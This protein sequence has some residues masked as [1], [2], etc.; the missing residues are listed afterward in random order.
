M[1]VK[2]SNELKAQASGKHTFILLDIMHCARQAVQLADGRHLAFAVFGKSLQQLHS[3]PPV[4]YH[5]GWPSSCIEGAAWSDA[6]AEEGMCM[7]A[8]DRPGYGGSTF[9]QNGDDKYHY[10]MCCP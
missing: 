10:V 2:H 6:A 8:V 5:H 4:I 1:H 9:N 7:V 3:A